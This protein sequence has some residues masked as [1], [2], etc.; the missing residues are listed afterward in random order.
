MEEN[1]RI[2]KKIEGTKTNMKENK[3]KII[4]NTGKTMGSKGT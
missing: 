3:R 4:V 2:C 1:E